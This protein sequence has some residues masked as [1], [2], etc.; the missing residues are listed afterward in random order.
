MKRRAKSAL[1][2]GALLALVAA[3]L[4]WQRAPLTVALM[5]RQANAMTAAADPLAAPRVAGYIMK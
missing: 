3:V 2:T 1:W 5:T 4:W